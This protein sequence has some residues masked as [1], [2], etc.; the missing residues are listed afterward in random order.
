[1]KIHGIGDH[2]HRKQAVSAALEEVNLTPSSRF[3]ERYPHQL[4]GGQRQ[5]VAVARAMVLDPALVLA[6]EPTSML[7]LSLRS[8][9][10]EILKRHRDA[11]GTGYLFITHDLALARH[12]CD[13]VAVMFGGK[14]AELG[15]TETVISNP[16]HPYTKALLQAVEELAPPTLYEPEDYQASD[17]YYG[18]KESYATIDSELQEVTPGHYVALHPGSQAISDKLV[19]DTEE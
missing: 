7:D 4:S 8:G 1:M 11:R 3:A 10:L 6:D 9:I 2:A 16:L 13:H 19:A 5:R 14:L 12:L 18:V 17:R 15:P